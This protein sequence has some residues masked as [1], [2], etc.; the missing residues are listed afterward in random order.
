MPI[1][2][3]GMSSGL[4][5]EALVS[6]L[7]SGYRTQKDNLVKAQTKLQWKQDKWNTMNT[8]IYSFYTGSLSTSRFSKNYTQHQRLQVHRALRLSSLQQQVILQVV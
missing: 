7:V 6:A 1:R 3:S 2:L 4:D 8:K 5:T